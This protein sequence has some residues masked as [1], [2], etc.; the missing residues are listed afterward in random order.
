MTKKIIYQNDS[1]VS[2][3][4]KRE[5]LRSSDEAAFG[6]S[7]SRSD[8][9]AAAANEQSLS[10]VNRIIVDETLP[11]YIAALDGTLIH[12]NN[13]YEK[14]YSGLDG[15]TLT[16]GPTSLM[17]RVISPSMEQLC[18]DVQSADTTV[19]VHEH[20]SINGRDLILLGRHIPVRSDTGEIIA[21]AGTYED[22]T[23]HHKGV[24]E[25]A[26]A[27][28]RFQ[29]FARASSDWFWEC[30]SRMRVTSI[31][32]R[33][34]AIVGSPASLYVGSRLEQ[35][36]KFSRNLEGREDGHY[37]MA[38]R[39]P[40]R[41]Q[42]F[43]YANH[44]G[45]IIRFHLSGVA[46]F[47]RE[48][49]E[50][51]GYRGVGMDVTQRYK[52][53]EAVEKTRIDLEDTLAELTR[54]NMA[55]DVV[56]V[57]AK[58]ALKA[59]NEFLASMSHELR[60]PLNAIIGF[61]D[62]ILASEDVVNET[63]KS[64]IGDIHNAGSHLL[65]LINDILDVAVIESGEL[66]L[67]NDVIAL[68]LSL[69]QALSLTSSM[70]E[71]KAINIDAVTTSSEL[72]IKADHRRF[73]QIIVNL[74][75]NAFKFTQEGGS[76]G[77]DI[78]TRGK[79]L[80]VT[81]WDTGM[82]IKEDDQGRVFEKFQQVMDNFYSRSQEGTGLGLHISRELARR[83]GGDITLESEVGKGSRFTVTALLAD[84][85]EIDEDDVQWI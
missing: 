56:S 24:R 25:T 79:R 45:E 81:V 3:N 82:G 20:V 57:Q 83:M 14:L 15:G 16:P 29:D 21:I 11:F 5:H 69:H 70:A 4:R 8:A 59:K 22:I 50:F 78:E 17:G 76:V 62:T 41:D 54:K 49:G 35:F 26:R 47:E 58:S 55:L 38:N 65:E 44:D 61:A 72:Y 23:S 31:S 39:K 64:Y 67:N 1:V 53:A 46:T 84:K 12:A 33:F 34:T 6:A 43:I 42:L 30:D 60:T 40:F 19:K 77:L 13:R 52:D 75:S 63:H 51:T 48:S 18:G 66:S 28:S 73:V 36:G 71:E 10:L 2:L 85:S 7:V 32:E 37:A 27:Q 9:R 74:L 68:D 80:A